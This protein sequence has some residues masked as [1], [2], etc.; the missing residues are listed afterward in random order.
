MRVWLDD[1]RPRPEGYT[2]WAK[3][4][5]YAIHLLKTGQVEFISLD[6]DLCP[7]HYEAMRLEGSYGVASS[8]NLYQGLTGYDVAL[9]IEEA[10][11]DRRIP[12]PRW[13]VH[14][15]NPCGRDRIRAAM[16]SAERFAKRA[17]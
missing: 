16:E 12:M 3:T 7:Q 2:A 13:R 17:D 6:H 10:V 11:K 14:T 1:L 4:A 8:A 5:E 9:W 15:M